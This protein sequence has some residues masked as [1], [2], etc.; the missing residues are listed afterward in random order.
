MTSIDTSSTGLSTSGVGATGSG[1]PGMRRQLSEE[2]KQKVEQL[3]DMLTDLLSES[4]GQPDEEQRGRIREVENEIAKI[5]GERPRRSLAA[6]TRKLPLKRKEKQQEEITGESP[7]LVQERIAQAT[8]PPDKGV[9]GPGTLASPLSNAASAYLAVAMT[10]DATAATATGGGTGT[11]TNAT[12]AATTVA[13]TGGT[14]KTRSFNASEG[15]SRQTAQ[16]TSAATLL[17]D[18]PRL[19]RQI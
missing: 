9:K 5:T 4:K 12:S 13:T 17:A 1:L 2:E 3:K 18:A 7:F 15:Y 11:A 6:T 19:D 10:M 14:G 8:L 16:P